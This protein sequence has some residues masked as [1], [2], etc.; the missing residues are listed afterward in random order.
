MKLYFT[1]DG[2]SHRGVTKN[3]GDVIEE[4]DRNHSGALLSV[5]CEVYDEIRHGSRP[6]K[7]IKPAVVIEEPVKKAKAKAKLTIEDMRKALK[8]DGQKVSSRSGADKIKNQY[9]KHFSK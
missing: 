4:N 1:K 2:I 6:A 5:G 3:K 8:D 7:A 9:E